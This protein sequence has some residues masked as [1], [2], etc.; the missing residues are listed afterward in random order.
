[1]KKIFAVIPAAVLAVGAL[2]G[3]T[4]SACSGKH[5]SNNYPNMAVQNYNYNTQTSTAA[6]N[7]QRR[8]LH[9]YHD[10]DNNGLCDCAI[11]GIGGICLSNGLCSSYY[12]GSGNFIDYNSDGICDNCASGT[13]YQ[14]G[15][16]HGAF[17]DNNHD[18][19]C[20]DHTGGVRLPNGLC[21][22]G[23]YC[24][25]GNFTDVN[26]DGICDNCAAGTCSQHG[27]H[28]INGN[29]FIDINGDGICDNCA[30]GTCSQHG[31]GL[32]TGHHQNYYGGH[33]CHH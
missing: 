20:D 28:H 4:A 11:N 17:V 14:H 6:V 5:N 8:S 18:G 29:N 32:V 25:Y 21:S 31:T 19:F 12:Y 3:I 13:C 15:Y 16:H 23:Y 10:A 1:M 30:A 24:G 33:G 9:Y 27:Y 22:G 7:A 2:T 26:G